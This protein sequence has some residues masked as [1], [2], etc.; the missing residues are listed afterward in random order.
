MALT[1]SSL[2][3]RDRDYSTYAAQIS[4][5][6][7]FATGSVVASCVVICGVSGGTLFPL[8]CNSAGYL[9]TVASGT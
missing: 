5:A 1:I 9:V 7:P 6:A 4:G 3:L 2:G 8:L